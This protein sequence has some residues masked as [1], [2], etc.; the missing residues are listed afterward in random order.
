MDKSAG[1]MRSRPERRLCPQ[2][3][4]QRPLCRIAFTQCHVHQPNASQT[5]HPRRTVTVEP[6][7]VLRE[8]AEI[9]GGS[10]PEVVRLSRGPVSSYEVAMVRNRGVPFSSGSVLIIVSAAAGPATPPRKQRLATTAAVL[11][12]RIIYPTSTPMA[13][14]DRR[15]SR[16]TRYSLEGSRDG[17]DHRGEQHVGSMSGSAAITH[18]LY[19]DAFVIRSSTAVRLR[20]RLQH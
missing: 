7:G 8:V 6:L 20:N 11:R 19:H 3:P 9:L 17:L 13:S 2:G 14:Q 4:D 5:E 15:S 16:T 18:A 1:E 12:T 10:R